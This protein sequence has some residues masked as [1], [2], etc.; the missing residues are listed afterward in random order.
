VADPDRQGGGGLSARTLAIASCASLTAAT[1]TSRVFPPG[2]IYASALT[3]VL[4]AAVSELL[5]RPANH[6]SELRR[7]RRAMQLESRRLE[8]SRMLGE[9]PSPLSG[10]P[11]FAQGAAAEEELVTGNGTGQQPGIRFD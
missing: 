9:A 3:P 10:A 6:V 5:N 7:Q 11:D 4:V 1:V 8:T 2:T